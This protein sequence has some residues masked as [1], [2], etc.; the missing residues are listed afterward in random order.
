MHLTANRPHRNILTEQKERVMQQYLKKRKIATHFRIS[1]LQ[2]A[3]DDILT[4]DIELQ[5][6]ADAPPFFVDGVAPVATS[7][8]P[9]EPLEN[10]HVAARYVCPAVATLVATERQ[11]GVIEEPA[12]LEDSG[13]GV[14]VTD[15]SDVI[16]FL[17]KSIGFFFDKAERHL[18]YI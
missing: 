1:I 12:Y 8:A 15:Q 3:R 9:G 4:H 7:V 5:F 18:R 13:I 14:Y 6:F 17:G 11:R 2:T 16:I 10:Q